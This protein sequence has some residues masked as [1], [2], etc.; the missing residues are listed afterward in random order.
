MAD[1]SNVIYLGRCNTY[2]LA[3]ANALS[4]AGFNVINITEL[5][6]S[7]LEKANEVGIII[8]DSTV[9]EVGRIELLLSELRAEDRITIA[10]VPD[11]DESYASELSVRFLKAGA[12]DTVTA[13][14][15]TEVFL[16]RLTTLMRLSGRDIAN[17]R[18]KAAL[19]SE[20]TLDVGDVVDHYRLDVVL[21]IGGMGVV[22]K[23]TDLNLDRSVALKILPSGVNLKESLIKRFLRE[24]EIM[25]HLQVPEAV[26]IYDVG[27]KPL[28]YIVMELISG[29]DLENILLERLF[30]PKEAVR[31]VSGLAK[32][33]YKIHEAGVI[34]RDL[35]PSNILLDSRGRWRIL[36]F[37][38][39]KLMD[40]ELTLTRPGA[41]MGTPD[42]MAPEQI[43]DKA[44]PIDAR[45]DIY[46][47]GIMMYEMMTGKVPFKETGFVNV[48]KEIV[49]GNPISLRREIPDIDVNLDKIVRKATSRKQKDRY[50]NMQEM[51]Q[52][53]DAL[54]VNQ[55]SYGVIKRS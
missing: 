51:A 32:A 21:G 7:F 53:L 3:Y 19:N 10:V 16:A 15:D 27:S 24:G 54:N 4:E 8:I 38:I 18:S 37:G 52:A 17:V 46:A 9:G 26:R 12:G 47:M 41:V 39:S 25:A 31:V 36:D 5:Q 42:Y 50:Q 20:Y 34:H 29:V 13:S 49:F 30:S 11:E 44:G 40:A 48:L 1:E 43:D 45:T 33:L 22:Y 23:A 35:K 14:G 2:N 28:N 55:P 6:D